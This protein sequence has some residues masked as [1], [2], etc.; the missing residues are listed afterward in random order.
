[1][2]DSRGTRTTPGDT[3]SG[4]RQSETTHREMMQQDLMDLGVWLSEHTEARKNLKA[5]RR[6]VVIDPGVYY[7]LGTGMIDRIYAP[8]HVAL[9]HKMYRISSDPSAPFEEIRR[10]VMEGR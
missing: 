9:G 10:K 8:Q 2:R 5:V 7:S 4:T 1:M 6:E 3:G